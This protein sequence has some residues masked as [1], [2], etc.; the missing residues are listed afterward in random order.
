VSPSP[1]IVIG[2]SLSGGFSHFFVATFLRCVASLRC[3]LSLF[4]RLRMVASFSPYFSASSLKLTLDSSHSLR[5]SAQL[6]TSHHTPSSLL[7]CFMFN[8]PHFLHSSSSSPLI[9]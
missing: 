8:L 2:G 6:V 3:Q 9:Y 7:E 1:S 5:I 4:F